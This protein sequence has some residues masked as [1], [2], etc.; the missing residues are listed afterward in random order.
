MP[1]NNS[2]MTPTGRHQLVFAIEAGA[3]YREAAA[4]FDIAISTISRWMGRWDEASDTQRDDLSCLSD[5]SS[6]PHRSPRRSNSRLEAKVARVR[7]R[8]GWG[9][10]LIAGEVGIAHQTVWKI[11]KRLGLLTKADGA[12]G[13]GHALR[14]ALP[15]RPP[16]HGYLPLCPLFASRPQDDR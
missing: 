1:H 13:A 3:S 8:T 5:R 7:R 4:M 10:R 16:A 2:R 12:Q 15:G 11:L 9:P 6:R 14:V